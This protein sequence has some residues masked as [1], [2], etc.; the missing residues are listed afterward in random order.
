MLQQLFEWVYR[1][2]GHRENRATA[3]P[4]RFVADYET[5]RGENI[6]AIIAAKLANLTFSDSTLQIEAGEDGFGGMLRE[7]MDA[8]KPEL[9]RITA[10][11]FGKGGKVLTPVVSGGRLVV[12]AMDQNRVDIRRME[13]G[14]IL[15]ATALLDSQTVDGRL[16]CLLADYGVSQARELTI[17]YRA[18]DDRGLDADRGIVDRWADVSEEI[19]I[20]EADR[21]PL[22][23]LCCPRDN[24][25]DGR[26]Y[27]VPITYGA[28]DDIAE[29][30]EHMKTY[31]REY[32]LT[33]PM[34]GLDYSLWRNP[35]DN[36]SRPMDI[37]M[38]RR[39]VQDS[40]DPFVPLEAS[41]LDSKGPWQMFSPQIRYT[42]MEGR[43]V[44][45]C[46]RIEK[47]C[48]LSQGILTERQNIAYANRDE[49]RAA[50]YDTFCTVKAM[51]DA[52]DAAIGLLAEDM[53]M[54]AEFFGLI[55]PGEDEEY[56]LRFDW[57]LS[58]IESAGETF[59]QYMRL[60]GIGGMGA[61][62]IRAWLLS[63]DV[64]S[65]RRA[66]DSLKGGRRANEPAEEEQLT[67]QGG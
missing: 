54:L 14:R 22:T 36:G 1:I 60:H 4:D 46:R 51:R 58:L 21:V 40:D 30:V 67:E 9:N 47:A 64:D 15:E 61:E 39:T 53:H 38:L 27:G 10:Q 17:R 50:M 16:Y 19:V 56:A 18:C 2:F 20:R 66:I 35:T 7:A 59:D 13:G 11:V 63:T 52:W 49:V 25:L 12:A 44:S 6:T 42:A 55:P 37:A 65:A 33:R 48:G 24:R 3:L 34:L 29:L 41:S 8:L 31:R 5:P 45:L 32:K 26:R 23:L 62:E 28:E 43:Y 57:D